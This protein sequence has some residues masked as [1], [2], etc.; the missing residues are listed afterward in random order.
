MLSVVYFCTSFI[1]FCVLCSYY[2]LQMLGNEL[3]ILGLVHTGYGALRCRA[4]S[5]GTA[6][7]EQ[8]V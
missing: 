1:A 4:L 7:K 6:N 5:H 3:N 8:S 2:L